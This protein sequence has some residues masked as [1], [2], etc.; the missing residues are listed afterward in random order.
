MVDWP[1]LRWGDEAAGE[2][3]GVFGRE[4]AGGA[5]RLDRPAVA[6]G[7]VAEEHDGAGGLPRADVGV[8]AERVGG[9][10]PEGVG[11]RRRA[12]H[13]VAEAVVFFLVKVVDVKQ[14]LR[15]GVAAEFGAVFQD[16]GRE[17]GPD[18]GQVVQRGGVGAVQV[19]ARD[20]DV[21]FEAP[22]HRVG[23]DEGF[24][25]VRLPAKS[26]AL[27]A[28]VVDRL[29]L[30]LAEPEALQVF[31]RHGVGVEAEVLHPPRLPPVGLDVRTVLRVP[32]HRWRIVA[33]REL[34]TPDVLLRRTPPTAC[35][36]GP[37]PLTEPRVAT[38]WR[39]DSRIRHH[40][41]A[42]I[43]TT[44][45]EYC[46][47]SIPVGFQPQ[48][49]GAGDEEGGL[50]ADDEEGER[51]GPHLERRHGRL[52]LV[53]IFLIHARKMARKIRTITRLIV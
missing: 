7:V 32:S 35:G 44:I 20:V 33:V 11:R 4:D 21:A 25:E 1:R 10:R 40:F 15:E 2:A 22:V 52:P 43:T 5:E 37:L 45:H 48:A 16:L 28:V 12:E 42:I 29:R 26:P 38:V 39:G 46:I 13:Q 31:D 8:E 17:P 53:R 30:L 51:D 24:G 27:R 9:Q 19:E 36:R 49:G 50:V 23:D 18:A 6:R 41:C 34:A 14:L 47:R 3:G